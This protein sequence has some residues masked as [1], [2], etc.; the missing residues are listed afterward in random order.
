MDR[1]NASSAFCPI[2]G[3]G[4]HGGS[5]GGLGSLLISMATDRARPSGIRYFTSKFS[6]SG[7][8][9]EGRASGSV[10][11]FSWNSSMMRRS[12]IGVPAVQHHQLR[13]IPVQTSA[14][15]MARIA[16]VRLPGVANRAEDDHV[17]ELVLAHLGPFN[18][19]I[20]S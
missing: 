11:S 4:G 2:S 1:P 6:R 7:M 19:V 15:D 5:G 12:Q 17:G 3:S 13:L 9:I 10:A 18:N 14:I 20:N 16:G 8:K